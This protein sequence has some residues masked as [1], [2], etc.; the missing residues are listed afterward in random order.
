[1]IE[2][3]LE[4]FAFVTPADSGTDVYAVSLK[5][6]VN[7]YKPDGQF[8]ESWSFTGYG[9][10]ASGGLLGSSTEALQKATQLAL[11]DAGA[12]LVTEL[13]EQAIVRGLMPADATTPAT[14]LPP[15]PQ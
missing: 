7:G 1:V 8:T 12:R 11:R 14:E 5:Y 2:P 10:A 4:D 13:R 15:P 6:R 3:V 9:A